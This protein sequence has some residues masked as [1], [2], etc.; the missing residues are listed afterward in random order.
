MESYLSF[1]IIAYGIVIRDIRSIFSLK[2]YMVYFCLC[3]C[4]KLVSFLEEL[5]YAFEIK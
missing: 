3:C 5:R 2:L 4:L 1:L